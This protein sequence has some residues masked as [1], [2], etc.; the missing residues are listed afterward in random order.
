MGEEKEV[1]YGESFFVDIDGEK[2]QY[3]L[4]TDPPQ[5]IYWDTYKV[6]INDIKIV[7]KCSPEDRK[8][9]KREILK[10]IKENEDE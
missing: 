6:K 2:W 1:T 10:D 8:R 4:N 9:L 7:T 3:E 5:A